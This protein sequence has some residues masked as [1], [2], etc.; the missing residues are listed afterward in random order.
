VHVFH[1][2]IGDITGSGDQHILAH[3]CPFEGHEDNITPAELVVA[4]HAEGGMHQGHPNAVE[5]FAGMAENYLTNEGDYPD[6]MCDGGSSESDG[7]PTHYHPAVG[8]CAKMIGTCEEGD[9]S[10]G[11]MKNC[12]D[13]IAL[14]DSH[15]CPSLESSLGFPACIGCS[16]SGTGRR[17]RGGN[18]RSL[19]EELVCPEGMEFCSE[20]FFSHQWG[21]ITYESMQN[22]HPLTFAFIDRMFTMPEADL[23]AL[24]A[25]ENASRWRWVVNTPL[26]HE[27]C[28]AAVLHED[29]CNYE[30]IIHDDC[31]RDEEGPPVSTEPKPTNMCI[32]APAM[33]D[34]V[35]TLTECTAGDK[36]LEIVAEPDARNHRKMRLHPI[37]KPNLCV[38]LTEDK[39]CE[40]IVEACATGYHKRQW[41][42]FRHATA[43]G[44][45][46]AAD[47]IENFRKVGCVTTHSLLPGSRVGYADCGVRQQDRAQSFEIHDLG[48]DK[49]RIE[50]VY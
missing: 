38:S 8:G 30:W 21:C 44:L 10:E 14:D 28:P 17:L 48:G 40:L 1:D 4:W 34:A 45:Q 33:A 23:D 32:R 35:A 11:C 46:G 49:Y 42:R 36:H 25:Q 37:D 13:M 22:T 12:D 27:R 7:G 6:G 19:T 24:I 15:T 3:C 9:T 16:C 18:V 50:A 43:N 41:W 20:K 31:H 5:W 2:A 29:K 39:S 26:G 47:T